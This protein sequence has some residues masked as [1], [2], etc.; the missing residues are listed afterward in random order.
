MGGRATG[1]RLRDGRVLESPAVLSTADPKRT[2]LELAEPGY[3]PEEFL[4]AVRNIKIHGAAMKVNLA[5][6]ELPN[7]A[8]LPGGPGPQHH[9]STY[10]CPSI[11]Y[12]EAA[13]ADARRGVPSRNPWLEVVTQSVLDPS[14][15]PPGKH[16]M[17]VYVQYTPY[18][19]AEGRWEDRREP[20]GEHVLDLLQVHVP[21]LR[22]VL[23]GKEVLTPA[24]LESKFGLTGGHIF[25]IAFQGDKAIELLQPQRR[26]R[27]VTVPYSLPRSRRYWPVWLSCSVGKG[28]PPTRVE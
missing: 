24:D 12:A 21:N 11:E 2:F 1:V 13:F 6:S 3:L 16:T 14:V 9:G 19:L 18:R 23:V 7:W 25:Q 17:S 15:A 5:L 20:L 10:L 22:S 26:G 4:R 8:A 28:P 27:R